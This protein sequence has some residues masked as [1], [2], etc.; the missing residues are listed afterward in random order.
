[1][2]CQRGRR[3]RVRRRRPASCSARRRRCAQA[4]QQLVAR[5]RRARWRRRAMPESAAKRKLRVSQT[6]LSRSA[7]AAAACRHD[8]GGGSRTARQVGDAGRAQR[9]VGAE[10]GEAPRPIR[11]RPAGPCRPAG[12]AAPCSG[13]ASSSRVASARSSI[14]ASSTTSTSMASGRPRVV[15]EAAGAGAQQ[16]VHG[17]RPAP[18]AARAAPAAGAAARWRSAS[19]MR[20]AALPVGA[21]SAMRSSRVL[22]EQA[23]QQVDHRGRL[24]GARAAADHHQPLAQ[25]QRGGELLP[26][27]PGA[28]WPN[29]ASS[30]CAWPRPRPPAAPAAARI[31]RRARRRS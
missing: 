30:R 6:T 18:A 12:S 19:L 7:L 5:G 8:V 28:A 20:A 25:R 27:G 21:A 10:L 31:R 1:M 14:E 17:A 9:R 24:A 2:H 11:P 16:P 13:T 26:V 3:R 29:S 15:R 22:L 23:G 4:L